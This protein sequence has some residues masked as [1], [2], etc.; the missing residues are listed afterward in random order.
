LEV[1]LLQAKVLLHRREGYV[2]DRHVERDHE[3]RATDEGED[4]AGTARVLGP[5]DVWSVRHARYNRPAAGKSSRRLPEAILVVSCVEATNPHR[6]PATAARPAM[7]VV[8][9]C[10]GGAVLAAWCEEIRSLLH[11]GT[12]T[13][14]E[15][16]VRTISGCATEVI[17]ALARL[18]LT[19]R[20]N[21]G[22]LRLHGA[23]A[24]LITLLQVAGLEHLA[25]GETPPVRAE[26]DDGPA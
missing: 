11:D 17:D 16:D 21:G 4:Q 3:L 24:T 5:W 9:R 26:S 20:R 13:V 2:H 8:G 10:D 19:A 12:A 23:D 7:V 6:D 15:C 25:G 22:Q 14:V 1:C 18:Q